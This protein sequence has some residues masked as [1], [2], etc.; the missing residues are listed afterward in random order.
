MSVVRIGLAQFGAELADVDANLEQMLAF[1]VDARARNA[2]VVCYP[3]LCLSGY[4]LDVASYDDQ[5]LRSVEAA[6]VVL[7]RAAADAGVTLVYGAPI[8][9]GSRLAN[10]VVH[11]DPAGAQL[12]Y[13]K[14][15]MDVKEREVF[16]RG[17]SF[18]VADGS[19]GLACCYDL[20]FPEPSR[21]LALRG[22]RILLVPMA[23]EVERGFVLER[24]AAARAVE[25]VVYLVCVNQCGSVGEFRFRGASCVLDPLGESLVTLGD[26]NA[27]AVIDLDLALVD[28]L[29]DRSDLRTYPLLDDRRPELYGPE[30]YGPDR[31]GSQ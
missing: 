18:V 23:W 27:L 26:E 3:E 10:G 4:L 24:V 22:A 29:R 2:D 8:R 15:H 5:L 6:Q 14:T 7:A 13:A 11:V 12:V 30:L 9:D 21:I 17:D 25:N 20:A 28:R 16:A 19:F 1:L 31:H